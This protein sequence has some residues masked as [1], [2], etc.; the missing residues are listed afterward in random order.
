[1]EI[2]SDFPVNN[3]VPV[4]SYSGMTQDSGMPHNRFNVNKLLEE[5]DEAQLGYGVAQLG[6]GAVELI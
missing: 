1:M 5:L 2:Y 6:E 4:Y 3:S